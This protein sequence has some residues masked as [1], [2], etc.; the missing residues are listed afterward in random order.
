MLAHGIFMLIGHQIKKKDLSERNFHTLYNLQQYFIWHINGPWLIHHL[1]IR[2]FSQIKTIL[3][4]RLPIWYLICGTQIKNKLIFKQLVPKFK[5]KYIR[6]YKV[7]NSTVVTQNL[8]IFPT[9]TRQIY[10]CKNL[11]TSVSNYLKEVRQSRT[12]KATENLAISFLHY[13]ICK[14]TARAKYLQKK[15]IS[16]F[17]IFITKN[18]S[19]CSLY[20]N[21]N[22]IQMCS[23]MKNMTNMF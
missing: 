12:Q 16:F 22:F 4:T 9:T 19:V 10:L 13:K 2:R 21:E 3:Y 1:I 11:L 15:L 6:L 7:Y 8:V 5:D 18:S 14:P 23:I 17:N 20:L